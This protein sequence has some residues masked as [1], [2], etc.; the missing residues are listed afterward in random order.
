VARPG[1]FAWIVCA[2][3]A[4]VV[5]GTGACGTGEAGVVPFDWCE[6]DAPPNEACFVE[7]RAP[8]SANIALALEIARAQIARKPADKLQWRWEEG[9]L[10]IGIADL[11]RV[12]GAEDLRDYLAAWIDHHV[13]R[14][15]DIL[16]SDTCPP[17]AVATL[18]YGRTGDADD[19]QVVED[20]LH[21]LYEVAART[22][23]G[24]IN[25]LGELTGLGVTLW[26]DSLFMFGTTL[27][28]WGEQQDDAQALDEFA[29]QYR[30]F[31]KHLQDGTGWF[32]HAHQWL[33]PHE[34]VHW[35]RGNGWVTAAA[36][37]YLRT[38]QVRGEED[39]EI[40]ASIAAQVDAITATQ[41]AATGLWRTLVDQ[42]ADGNYL[43]TSGAALF[44]YGMARGW[45]IGLLDDAVLPIIARA[46][47]GVRGR[48]VRDDASN[49]PVV[50]GT[51]GPTT[52]G[53]T[54][55]YLRVAQADDISY[56]IGAVLLALIETSGLPETP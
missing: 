12:T 52:A 8:D 54:A 45:R 6:A 23:D 3:L 20:V 2:A 47:D 51:S 37:E 27:I 22:D 4:I 44:A 35:A 19:R 40:A 32:L 25:H 31:A 33:A 42:E 56:G 38:R 55:E 5:I 53:T 15:Y 46:M 34:D 16:S 11:Y 43:E 14:G 9:V 18:L 30:V 21:Y 48:I 29:A 26:V 36:Y 10:M 28:R 7:K 50:T 17:A 13:D 24:G 1:R 49:A 41:D 39:P